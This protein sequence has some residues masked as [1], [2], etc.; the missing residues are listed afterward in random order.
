LEKS[1]SDD[2]QYTFIM[3]DHLVDPSSESG[4]EQATLLW[5]IDFTIPKVQTKHETVSIFLCWQDF[6]PTYRGKEQPRKHGP[7]LR[8]IKRFSFMMRRLVVPMSETMS[9]WLTRTV[10][11][12]VN[13]ETSA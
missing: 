10:S 6:R 4:R 3:K 9:A 8:S 13:K 2:K 5:E 11:L 12:V 1:G 7:D